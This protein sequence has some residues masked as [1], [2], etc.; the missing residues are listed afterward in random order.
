MI[1]NREIDKISNHCDNSYHHC[2]ARVS[3]FV[4]AVVCLLA[5]LYIGQ[6][7]TYSLIKT[8]HKLFFVTSLIKRL[9]ALKGRQLKIHLVESLIRF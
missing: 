3:S 4:L 7:S 8:I 5:W 6:R 9:R 2:V 1:R